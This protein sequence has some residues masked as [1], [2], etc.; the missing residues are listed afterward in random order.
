MIHIREP[1]I[2]VQ[3]QRQT[4]EIVSPAI[5]CKSNYTVRSDSYF[6]KIINELFNILIG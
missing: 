6:Q 4:R 3:E 5:N 1:I 2:S